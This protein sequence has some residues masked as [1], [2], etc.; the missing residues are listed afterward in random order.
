M[1]YEAIVLVSNALK[2]GLQDR[3]NALDL[4]YRVDVA[5][6]MNPFEDDELTPVNF[7]AVIVNLPGTKSPAADFS[8]NDL[9]HAEIPLVIEYRTREPD[10]APAR[11]SVS[12]VQRAMIQVLSQ[13]SLD[14]STLN[15]IKLV[16]ISNLVFDFVSFDG[17]YTGGAVMFNAMLRDQNNA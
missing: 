16:E 15:D 6:F 2:A 5:Q 17:D 11:A 13:L 7:P 10:S 1:V 3:L 9:L 8:I 4:P 12:R 14:Q